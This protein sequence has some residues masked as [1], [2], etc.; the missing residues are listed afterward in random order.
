MKKKPSALNAI[1]LTAL[2][3][4][5]IWNIYKTMPGQ[6]ARYTG[7]LQGILGLAIMI[8]GFLLCIKLRQNVRGGYVIPVMLLLAFP[9]VRLFVGLNMMVIRDDA[10]Q[11]RW[12]WIGLAIMYLILTPFCLLSGS[13]ADD[14]AERREKGFVPQTKKITGPDGNSY[15]VPTDEDTA[16]KI[17]KNKSK[18]IVLENGLHKLLWDTEFLELLYEHDKSINATTVNGNGEYE[19]KPMYAFQWRAVAEAWEG[20]REYEHYKL[21]KEYIDI[22]K[23]V[24]FYEMAAEMAY[25]QLHRDYIS[26]D[27][28]GVN[29][30]SKDE[31]LKMT[32]EIITKLIMTYRNGAPGIAP[33]TEKAEYYKDLFERYN[34]QRERYRKKWKAAK[35]K[36]AKKLKEERM[37]NYVRAVNNAHRS[38]YVSQDDSDDY[39]SDETETPSFFNFPTYIYDD[40]EN[41]WQL[42]N[43]GYDN[44]TYYCQKTGETEMFYKSDFSIGSPSGF[45]RR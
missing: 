32:Q 15:L 11:T 40:D 13:V 36:E 23:A 37:R 19:D 45:H 18:E 7:V 30:Y 22:K 5:A 38:S 35:D 1:V 2:A 31:D 43:S 20:I 12:E 6:V 10:V 26:S 34:M 4:G 28:V 9:V 8:L 41:P 21:P 33:S 29:T 44:A 25:V 24:H 17:R 39:E 16:W 42:I 3:A 27:A 14:E